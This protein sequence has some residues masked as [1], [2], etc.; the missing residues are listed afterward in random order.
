M[1]KLLVVVD[2]QIDFVT[3]AL[4]F[5]GAEKL[6]APIVKKIKAYRAEGCDIAFTFDTHTENYLATQEGRKL[7]V[8]HC[9]KGT[10]GWRL[11]GETAH[12][13][14]DDDAVF[15]KPAFGSME[16]A[17][18]AQQNQ[19]DCV[20]LVGL[21]SN[22]CV[23]SNAALIKAALPEAEVIVDASCTSCFDPAANEKALDVMEGIQIT[24]INRK[25]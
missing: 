9:I 1:K 7:P 11:F 4:G 18:F 13:L 19:Y 12:Q 22:I 23:I 2:Y 8:T 17:A 15:Y 3:G 16:L 14:E 5:A 21:V 25:K 10:E 20:E 24:V 6:D